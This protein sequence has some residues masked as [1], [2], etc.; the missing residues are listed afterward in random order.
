MRIG[1]NPNKEVF[2]LESSFVHQIIVPVYIPHEKGYFVDAYKILKI[3]LKSLFNTIDNRT[4]ITIIND[5]SCERVTKY[6]DLLFFE[7]KINELV[8]T[9]NIGKIN[10][11]FKGLSGNNIKLVTIADADVLFLHDWQS[12]T[13]NVFSTVPKAGVVGIVPQ[14]KMYESNCGNIIF[15]NLFNNKMQFI[16]IKNRDALV[17]FYDS[18]GWDRNY[19][20]DYLK[21]GLG[22]KY[23]NFKCFIGS[24][25]FVATYKKDIFEEIFTYIGGKK[26]AGI[27]EIYI[28]KKPLEKGYFR[29]T[30]YDN[31]AYHMGNIFE[32]WMIVPSLNEASIDFSTINF[33]KRKQVSFLNYFLKNRLF[34]KALSVQ[35]INIFFLKWKKLPKSMIKNF[36]STVPK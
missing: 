36:N 24:G 13:V 26:A 5:G 10:A 12:E 34:V 7:N 6:L 25:H 20:Q 29:L 22:L 3:C 30:T 11:V 33:R 2:Q 8:H 23:D 27:G 17:R 35:W 21:F 1:S 4:Y 19:N 28:D 14:F 31:F 16:P 9:H 32:D 18:I 15:D